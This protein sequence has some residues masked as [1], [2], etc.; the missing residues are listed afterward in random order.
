M[1]EFVVIGGGPAG[2]T[3][4]YT[5]A[6]RGLRPI[7]LEQLAIVGG[8]ARTE[9]HHGFH[10]DMGGHR[11]FTKVPEVEAIWRAVL[12]DDF[13]KRPRLSRIYYDGK[14]FHYPL[15]PWNALAG[16]G[17]WQAVMVALSY[18]RWQVAPHPE[19][20]TFE[21]WVTNRFGRRLFRTFF[22]TYTEK[23]WGVSCSELKAEWAAQRIKDLSLRTA[24]LNMFVRPQRTIKTL[25]EEF[26]YPRLGPGMMWNAMRNAIQDRGGGVR[27]GSE[28]VAI[29]REGNR[30]RHV[31]VDEDGTRTTIPG[32][33]F[34]SSMP[35]TELV[36]R[37]DPPAPAEVRAAARQLGYRDF[38]T[39]CLIF[40]APDLF[41]DNWIY[42][43]DP[44]V[45]VG[46]IQNFK[47]WSPDMVPDQTRT[48]LGLEYFC[49]EGDDLWNMPDEE[50]IALGRREI[51]AIGLARAEDVVDGCVRRVPKAYPIYDAAYR[52]HLDVV[53][54]FVDGLANV[55]TI[56]RNGLHRY[57]NQ[58]HAMVTGML[59]VRNLVDGER[60]DLW[61][62][63]T[64]QEYLE[65]VRV[66]E[67]DAFATTLERIFAKVDRVAFGVALGTVSGLVLLL[68]TLVL[69]LKGGETVGPH[70]ALLA[71]YFPGYRVSVTGS[72][73]G[74]VY[75]SLVG[76]GLGWS[77][78]LVRNIT[79][80]TYEMA[81]RRRTRSGPFGRFLDAI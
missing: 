22:K 65:E 64:D 15:K 77:L 21:Q 14:F 69:A 70:L 48:S 26:D 8:L 46:R 66:P 80:F 63:N 38:L 56:G 16:L 13:I 33:H 76:F 60:H 19:E 75:G 42:I 6:E 68:T 71:Q 67:E 12:G 25:I 17:A 37:L 27:T 54:R 57:D 50:L 62:V 41:P 30:V 35:I 40:D 3:A 52:E 43:H 11:F 39:V 10:F 51:A 9:S 72:V 55:Q 79:L 45:R 58:D 59:A 34:I 1:S 28:V 73:V 5:L 18:V 31:V 47:N 81:L 49:T 32:T 78:A 29:G 2:L 7:V 74:L 23:V 20:E 24:V 44:A 53:R 61:S 4:A 36:A